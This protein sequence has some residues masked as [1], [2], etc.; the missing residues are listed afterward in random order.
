[1]AI[2]LD[3]KLRRDPGTFYSPLGSDG[4]MLNVNTGFYHGLNDVGARIWELLETPETAAQLLAR[5]LEEF[6]VEEQVCR[7]AMLDFLGK[8]LDRGVIHAE[9]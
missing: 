9:P 5:L 1:V 8:L 7:A 3:T 2:T 6:E 4:V